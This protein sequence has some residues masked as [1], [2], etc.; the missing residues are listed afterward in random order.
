MNQLEQLQTWLVNYN[1][2]HSLLGN[3]YLRVYDDNA[4]ALWSEHDELIVYF[5][6]SNADEIRDFLLNK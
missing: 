6:D 1:A 3:S 2:R 4:I 5:E